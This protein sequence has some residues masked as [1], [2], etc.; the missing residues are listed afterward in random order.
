MPETIQ[1]VDPDGTAHT[2]SPRQDAIATLF[3]LKG[4]YMPPVEFTEDDV[5]LQP[6]SR[7]REARVRPREVDL[8]VMLNGTTESIL[9][10][11]L[12]AWLYRLDPSR[13]DG[14]LRVTGPDGS[15]REIICRYS[16]GMQGDETPSTSGQWWQKALFVLRAVDPFWY[17]VSPIVA[18]YTVGAA[19]AFFPFFPLV[20]ATSGVFASPTIVNAGD[21]E[22][23]LVWVA[24]GPCTSLTLTNLTTGKVLA[25][26]ATLVAGETVTIDT[27]PGY[28][29]VVKTSIG[30]TTSNLFS[31]LSNTSSLWP[32]MHGSNSVR[33]EMTGTAAES[34]ARLIYYERWLGA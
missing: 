3:D 2:I 14:R 30:G 29:T 20:L 18:T 24:V 1:W 13:G 19:A 16:T 6:G 17:S 34:E 10:Q 22:A 32:L 28:K 33:I 5:P 26:T 23:W 31:S 8:A 12:R 25:L 27:R 21:V 9:R 15:Q 4:R 7:L 11:N